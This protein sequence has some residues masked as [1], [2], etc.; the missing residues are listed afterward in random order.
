MK[1]FSRLLKANSAR[2]DHSDQATRS[3]YWRSLSASKKFYVKLFAV[4]LLVSATL[5]LAPTVFLFGGSP[6][7]S[8]NG[9][10]ASQVSKAKPIVGQAVSFGG[11][12]PVS[13]FGEARP[14]R[15]KETELLGTPPDDKEINVRNV[16][17][18]IKTIKTGRAT[19]SVDPLIQTGQLPQPTIP[20]PS[21]SFDGN[22]SD[23]NLAA[24]GGRVLPPDTNG[25]VGPNHFI[26]TTNLLV[27][28]YNKST[29]ALVV[30]KFKMSTLFASVGAPCAGTDAGDP[31][32]L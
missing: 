22:S 3:S 28:I 27:G 16:D 31:I 32:V 20:S 14:E 26:Q 4:G 7:K 8:V 21:V 10:G 17:E 30:P 5:I 29:G 11:T 2:R 25:V 13:S 15:N 9:G 1:R 24:F 19:R 12:P 18:R 6:Q 23:D